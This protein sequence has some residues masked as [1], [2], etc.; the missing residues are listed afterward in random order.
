MVSGDVDSAPTLGCKADF[1]A[2]ASIPIDTN[3]PGARSA[4]VVLDQ[5]GQRLGRGLVARSE[6]GANLVKGR[7]G[8]Q[9]LGHDHQIGRAARLG[10]RINTSD[11][12]TNAPPKISTA[13]SVS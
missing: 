2:L 6:R 1:D 11:A 8:G 10:N 12:A 9:N 4:K 5:L 13:L 7:V 3:I